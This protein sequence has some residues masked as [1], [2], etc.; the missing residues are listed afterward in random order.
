MKYAFTIHKYKFL[1]EDFLEK[2]L[3]EHFDVAKDLEN[4][5]SFVLIVTSQQSDDQ[6]VLSELQRELDRIAFFIG[7]PI[8]PL[9][10]YKE[11]DDGSRENSS[12]IS[13][14]IRCL[15]QIPNSL[16]PQIWTSKLSV[17]LC[18]WRLAGLE[19]MPYPAEINLL[20]QIVEMSDAFQ[21]CRLGYSDPSSAPDSLVEARL[22]RN[23][24]SHNEPSMKEE[25]KCYCQYLGIPQ[26]FHDPTD[27]NI[28]SKIKQRKEIVKKRIRK[29]IEESMS[30]CV[31]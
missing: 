9:K 14:D 19:E 27:K 26:K 16:G 11:N 2:I 30:Y 12:M 24:V 5:K 4:P 6:A 22:L 17:Q 8:Y 21:E 7:H 31:E 3:P 20:F 15:G 29:I 28:V 1:S 23:L 18:L 10:K 13:T 25:L